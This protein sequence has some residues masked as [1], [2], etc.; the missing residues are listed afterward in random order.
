MPPKPVVSSANLAAIEKLFDEYNEKP[1]LPAIEDAVA[2]NPAICNRS[3]P[4]K[5]HKFV[6]LKLLQDCGMS[7]DDLFSSI[8]PYFILFKM[9]KHNYP[10]LVPTPA[11]QQQSARNEYSYYGN[12]AQIAEREAAE[13]KKA[14]D[15][16]NTD[17]NP[18]HYISK[19]EFCTA[20]QAE[21][22][23][24]IAKFSSKVGA[25]DPDFLATSDPEFK[26]FY[27]WMFD[28]NRKLNPQGRVQ[29]WIVMDEALE[30]LKAILPS[31]KG[32]H[33]EAF[34]EWLPTYKPSSG[35]FENINKDQWTSFLTFS[36]QIKP[37]YQNYST[38]TGAWPVLLD[39][40]VRHRLTAAAT[41][42][43]GETV[44]KGAGKTGG[45]R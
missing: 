8:K 5:M 7:D 31:P 18:S 9:K 16:K 14:E 44:F 35:V 32:C 33:T 10:S 23:D 41:P 45:G 30:L 28:F 21:N 42:K 38:E 22:S 39:D 11:A 13:K 3:D 12:Q 29:K 43:D 36:N 17:I 1:L 24:S 19:T 26:G 37:D 34:A 20:M 2:S 40:F 27:N 6:F 25:F 4:N 15:A